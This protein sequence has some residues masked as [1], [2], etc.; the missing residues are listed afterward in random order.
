MNKLLLVSL[1]TYRKDNLGS[2]VAGIPISPFITRTMKEGTYYDNYFASCNWTIP[3]YASMF[4]G[5]PT[6][7]HNFWGMKRFPGQ[8]VDLIFDTL[9]LAEI[10]PSLICCGVLAE[11]D[12]FRY[13]TNRYFATTY[14]T[15]NLDGM[16]RLI[17]NR[18]RESDFVFFHT[19]LMHDYFHHYQYLSPQHGIK[20]RYPFI[21]EA[22]SE[23]MGKKMKLWREEHF[24]MTYEDLE[25]VQAMY[26]NECLL[27]D[28]FVA[29][30]FE[31]VLSRYPDVEVIV[32]S[33]HGECFSQ[34]GKRAFDGRWN[35][36]EHP[37]WHHSTGFC[38]E[39][40][41][42]FAIEYNSSKKPGTVSRDLM[43][44][45]DIYRMIMS[46]F[47]LM[48]HGPAQKTY[49]IISTSYDRVGFCGVLQDGNVYLYDRNEDFRFLLKDNLYSNEFPEPDPDEIARYRQILVSRSRDTACYAEA[50]AEVRERLKGFGYL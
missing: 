24:P 17:V 2:V 5:E 11:S 48:T 42:V 26:Y 35:K 37:L 7:S 31:E 41:H 38:F 19:F 8:P 20:R 28:D 22:Q 30:L 4:T 23:L 39:Q 25:I 49:N 18:L 1:D 13:R 6:V 9:A 21:D 47:G 44:H 10:R 45:E 36:S 33:D 16:I 14:D 50:S 12:I 46:R 27:V 29:R 32:N 15:R 40:F 3:S 34:C 43:D